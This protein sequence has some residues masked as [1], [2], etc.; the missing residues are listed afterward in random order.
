MKSHVTDDDDG[1]GGGGGD[2]DDDDDEFE[3]RILYSAPRSPLRGTPSTSWVNREDEQFAESRHIVVKW[4]VQLN[5][6]PP[7]L[8]FWKM[9]KLMVSVIKR[10]QVNKHYSKARYCI[11]FLNQQTSVSKMY[12]IL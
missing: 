5:P 4:Q 12:I 1:G 11:Y 6:F 8:F 2:D 9:S 7:E 3:L 10:Q